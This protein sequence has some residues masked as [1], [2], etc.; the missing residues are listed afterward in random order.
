MLKQQTQGSEIVIRAWCSK[1]AVTDFWIHIG[2]EFN[3]KTTEV[4]VVHWIITDIENNEI[5]LASL[6]Y[7]AVQDLAEAL[8]EHCEFYMR[9]KYAE[10]E[11][12][13]YQSI[14]KGGLK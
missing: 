8:K 9:S 11:D 10:L 6:S 14:I 13:Y 3:S 12:G 5:N 1:D 2:L 7:T 4:E